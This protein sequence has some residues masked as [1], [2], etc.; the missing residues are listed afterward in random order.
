MQK[1]CSEPNLVTAIS[2]KIYVRHERLKVKL[3]N[4]LVYVLCIYHLIRHYFVAIY[5]LK[6]DGSL[7]INL[8][9]LEY[10]LISKM[11]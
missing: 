9:V 10:G 11:C 2:W 3:N 7:N 1:S 4:Y 8:L 5:Y 6:F